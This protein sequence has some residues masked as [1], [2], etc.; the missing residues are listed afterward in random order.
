MTRLMPVV[1]CVLTCALLAVPAVA[2]DPPKK[3]TAQERKNLEAEFKDHE[4]AGFRYMAAE[5]WD[6]ADKAL[7]GALEIAA[8]LYPREDYPKGQPDLARSLHSVGFLLMKRERFKEAEPFIREAVVMWQQHLKGDDLYVSL[9]L[10]NLGVVLQSQGKHGPAVPF[11]RE[12]LAMKRRLFGDEHQS[13]SL[14]LTWLGHALR[15]QGMLTEAEPLFREA[16]KIDRKLYPKRQFPVGHPELAATLINVGNSFVDVGQPAGAEEVFREAAEMCERLYPAG[17]FPK[18]DPRVVGSLHGLGRSLAEQGKLIEAERYCRRALELCKV[19]YPK[20][21]YPDGHPDLLLTTSRLAHVL[22]QQGRDAEVNRLAVEEVDFARRL[23]SKE[24]FP[25]GHPA[26]SAALSNAAMYFAHSG[27]DV[28][29]EQLYRESVAIEQ[30]LYPE[31]LYPDGH[32]MVA[33]GLSNFGSFLASYGSPTEAKKLLRDALSMQRKLYP[34]SEFAEGHPDLVL[35]L[36]HLGRFLAFE[37]EVK[38]AET[39]L[40]EALALCRKLYPETKYPAGHSRI[41]GVLL[42]LSFLADARDDFATGVAL[43]RECL[44]M[45]RALYPD[46]QYPNGHPTTALALN[47]L[48]FALAADGRYADAEATYRDA[49]AAMRKLYPPDQYPS[50][51]WEMV[52]AL[53]GYATVLASREKQE[54][55]EDA[56][57]EALTMHR[58]QIEEY[59]AR[60]SEGH[61][62]SRLVRFSALKSGWLSIT[63]RQTAGRDRASDGYRQMWHLKSVVGRVTEKGA[64]ASRYAATDARATKLLVEL[65]DAR[66]ERAARLL[67][68]LSPDRAT[69]L[70][71]DDAISKTSKQI[72]EL[73]REVRALVPLVVRSERLA[74]ASPADLQGLLPADAVVVDFVQY[75]RFE[76]H[77]K[78]PG[79]AGQRL[80]PWYTAFVLTREKV[81]CVDVGS[82]E[83]IEKAVR[84]WREAVTGPGNEVS[85]DIPAKVRELVWEKVHKELPAGVKVVY[86]SPDAGL[87]GVPWAALPGA[88]AGTIILEDHAVATI[89]HAPFLL[90]QLWSQ[91]DK[92]SRK[93]TAGALVVGGVAFDDAPP[94]PAVRPPVGDAA[95][96]RGEPPRADKSGEALKWLSLRGTELEADGLNK[97]ARKQKLESTLITGKDASTD[98]VLIE[99]PKARF[100]HFATHGFFADPSFRSVL[101]VNP[102]DFEVTHRGERVGAGALNP[103]VMSGLVFA[104]ANRPETRGRGLVT[105]EH[106]IDRDLSGLDLA[107][108][109]A[110]DTGLGDVAGGEGVFGL[111]RAFHVAGCR[112]VVASLWKVDDDATAVLMHLFYANMWEQ[113]LSPV[114]ALRQAQLAVYRDAAL[115]PAAAKALRGGEFIVVPA[116]STEAPPKPGA[117]GKAHPRTWAAFTLSG[118]GR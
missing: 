40:R 52:H 33:T 73:E 116:K 42:Q 93:P 118:F 18:S 74:K 70:E 69:Q 86:V 92:T 21:E 50:G 19:C 108:L 111:Q 94:A 71:R 65:A 30:R 66:E 31:K 27:R 25:N 8:R 2:D 87:T 117:G 85:A 49:V 103:M 12:S 54:A 60:N 115:V 77:P 53:C 80:A 37:G 57:R 76:P 61:A 101:Q 96:H 72:G 34:K 90:D 29:A 16:L 13:V 55:A 24:R 104:G 10:S 11:L 56:C 15:D 7:K 106:L 59:A 81:L 95:R 6:D 45:C 89:P 39:L 58:G 68:P 82:A 22:D 51:S 63:Q 113:K 14:D 46:K 83:P 17:R 112:N 48:G 78:P 100:A 9:G 23:Y 84:L 43:L 79:R 47:H 102:N 75:V 109:S 41:V 97:L 5:R 4:T 91:D 67:A 62:L 35:S 28:E 20:K 99:L 44:T 107:V 64:L 3:L 114:E 32:P 26:L 98:R 1:F 88:K 105:G 110:C 38:E 36:T